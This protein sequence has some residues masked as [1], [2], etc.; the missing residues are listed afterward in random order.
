METLRQFCRR[1][2]A[3]GVDL[4]VADS[5]T[6]NHPEDDFTPLETIRRLCSVSGRRSHLG[7]EWE[8]SKPKGR[9]LETAS[10]VLHDA[11]TTHLVMASQHFITVLARTDS[12][13]DLE[14]STHDGVTI[15]T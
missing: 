14:D 7:F 4:R 8:T 6:G 10:P 11:V 12:H 2:T 13:T 5:H 3:K 1:P 9:S 15:K